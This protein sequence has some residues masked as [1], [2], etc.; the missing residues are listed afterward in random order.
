MA[1][2]GVLLAILLPAIQSGRGQA[3]RLECQSRL[4]PVSLAAANFEATHRKG[5]DSVWLCPLEDV[6]PSIGA[7]SV[8]PCDGLA[9]CEDTP[10]GFV[11]RYE[12]D[13]GR[14]I[15]RLR[16]TLEVVDGLSQ[17]IQFS[18]RRVSLDK[19]LT[20]LKFNVK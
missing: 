19:E 17:T 1:I 11:G 20:P 7:Y 12:S 14:P 6:R 18:E 4:K 9:A 15:R 5:A 13:Q 16:S 2:I 3:R 8:L 10:S